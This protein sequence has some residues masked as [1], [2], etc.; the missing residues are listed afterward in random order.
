MTPDLWHDQPALNE[1][2]DRVKAVR[3]LTTK[4]GRDKRGQYLV[5][6]PQSVR[7]ALRAGD[8]GGVLAVY[9][10]PA[11][12]DRHPEIGAAAVA[13][14]VHPHESSDAV[15]AAM[16]GTT[17][18]GSNAQGILAVC[19]SPRTDLASLLARRPRLVAVLSQVRDPGNAGTVIRVADAAGADAVIVT[20]G[21]VDVLSP[22]VVRSTAGSL[23]HL[24]VVTG[25]DFHEAV[26][27]LRESGCGVLAADGAGT[28]L[29][30]DLQ[31][32]AEAGPD[33][34]LRRPTAWIFG[35]EAWGLAAADREAADRVVRIPIHGSAESLNLAMAATVC[36]YASAR[37]LRR[38]DSQTESA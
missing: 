28:E 22:K 35:N 33:A 11:A 19:R 25:V 30:S 13:A 34:V 27:G 6:G 10:T 23:F 1:R 14:D 31:D 17:V 38:A 2:S 21:S 29:L 16:T 26:A 32:E 8:D 24:P 12:L 36:L 9:A 5:E 4:A 3:A 37:E 7:E 15:I 18:A 20:A